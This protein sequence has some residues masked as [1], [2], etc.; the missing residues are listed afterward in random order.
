M[1]ITTVKTRYYRGYTMVM[2]RSYYSNNLKCSEY[3]TKKGK[4]RVLQP[5]CFIIT[6]VMLYQ[7]SW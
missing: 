3:K 1:V 2:S 5:L 7:V 4:H 6:V